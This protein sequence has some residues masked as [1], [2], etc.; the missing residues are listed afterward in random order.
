MTKKAHLSIDLPT[1]DGTPAAKSTVTQLEI[2]I[3]KTGEYSVSNATEERS[4]INKQLKTLKSALA[5]M[6]N[7]KTDIPVIVT[8]DANAPHQAVVTAME[9]AGSQGFKHL[10]ITTRKETSE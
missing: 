1:A 9:A 2:I 8:A 7:G 4:L 10:S 3:S 5:K 6:S